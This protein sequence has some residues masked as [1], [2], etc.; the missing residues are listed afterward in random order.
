MGVSDSITGNLNSITL[1]E[2]NQ[3]I[4]AD[5]LWKIPYAPGLSIFP[6]KGAINPQPLINAVNTAQRKYP[7]SKLM[8]FHLNWGNHVALPD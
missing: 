7:S 2:F 1:S 4:L 5:A 8:V 6:K 3:I